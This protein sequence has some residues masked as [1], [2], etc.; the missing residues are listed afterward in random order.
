MNFNRVNFLKKLKWRRFSKKQKSTNYNRIFNQILLGH[1][2]FYLKVQVLNFD[3][4]N[5]LF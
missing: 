3:R 4:I 1:P 2:K 5:F